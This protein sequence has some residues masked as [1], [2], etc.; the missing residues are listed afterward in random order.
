[1]HRGLYI[2]RKS[3]KNAPLRQSYPATLQPGARAPLGDLCEVV[4]RHLIL[5]VQLL[6]LRVLRCAKAFG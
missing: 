3:S 1:M 4:C 2:N 6:D 5:V